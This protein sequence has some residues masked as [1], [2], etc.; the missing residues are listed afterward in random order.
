MPK[1][2]AA[3]GQ[4]REAATAAEPLAQG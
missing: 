4:E 2:D 1:V 3:V